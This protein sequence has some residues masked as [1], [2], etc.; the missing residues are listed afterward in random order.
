MV[1][2]PG[3]ASAIRRPTI[4]GSRKDLME[5]AGIK[6][7]GDLGRVARRGPK[8]QVA[9]SSAP[10]V[11]SPR[12]ARRRSSSPPSFMAPAGE[13]FTPITF[14]SRSTAMYGECAR[15][16]Q[17]HARLSPPGA[18]GY[19]LAE[20]VT[21][22]VSGACATGY[23]AGRVLANVNR[24]PG[25]RRQDHLRAVSVPFCRAWPRR[26]YNDFPSV[27]IPKERRIW[28]PPSSSPAFLFEPEG[29]IDQL[30]AAPG[31][32]LPS[33]PLPRTPPTPPTRSS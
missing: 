5:K 3:P 33:R 11:H 10:A 9:E 1:T 14:R 17:V 28:T 19:S 26:R 18:T 29:Y 15:V 6:D 24:E 31:H 16:L 25:H 27:F 22:F 7:S 12:T 13:L 20:M 23:Y 8:M 30:L 32:V 4:F 21:G 2:S